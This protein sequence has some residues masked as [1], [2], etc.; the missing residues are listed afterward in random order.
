ME[1][2]KCIDNSHTWRNALTID[3]EYKIVKLYDDPYAGYPMIEIVCDDGILRPYRANRFN[4][5]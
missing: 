5:S 1:N 3:K 2:A 4:L